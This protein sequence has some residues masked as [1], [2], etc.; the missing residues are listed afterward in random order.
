[1]LSQVRML[2]H[3]RFHGVCDRGSGH[4]NSSLL[5]DILP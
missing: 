3:Q 4:V 5:A 1:M 2:R